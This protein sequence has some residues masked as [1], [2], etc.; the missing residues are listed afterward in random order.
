MHI[1]FDNNRTSSF[2]DHQHSSKKVSEDQAGVCK[3][4][5]S[6]VNTWKIKLPVVEEGN[7][8]TSKEIEIS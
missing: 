1:K 6:Q 2:G 8:R 4:N 7:L 3:I 5:E